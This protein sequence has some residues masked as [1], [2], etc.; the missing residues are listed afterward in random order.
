MADDKMRAALK[1]EPEKVHYLNGDEL[2]G[3]NE[4]QLRTYIQRLQNIIIDLGNNEPEIPVA[5][6]REIKQQLLEL[7]EQI[8]TQTLLVADQ[9]TE[10]ENLR[11]KVAEITS[12]VK[13]ETM[14]KA[15]RERL[16]KANT[17]Y[18][19]KSKELRAK[20]QML[21]VQRV[22]LEYLHNMFAAYRSIAGMGVKA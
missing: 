3:M 4:A 21:N 2:A 17:D 6:V 18:I 16:L 13:N 22:H 20:E 19:E 9:T 5:G 14:C 7:P 8:K 10:V 11:L 1:S 12:A 15:K